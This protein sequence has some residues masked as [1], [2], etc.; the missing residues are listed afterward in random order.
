MFKRPSRY[1]QQTPEQ[2][3]AARRRHSVLLILLVV[4]V[5]A[6][7]L[8]GGFVWSDHADILDGRHRITDVDDVAAVLSEARDAYR[9]RDSG[10]SIDP[11][12]GS[13]QPLTALSNTISWTLWGDCGPCLHAENL[14]LHL[15]LVIG[16]YALGRHLLSQ[17]RRGN[18]I[19][20]WAAAL[21][22]IHPA[23]VSSVAWIGG[24]PYLLAAALGVWSLVIFT[25]LQATSRSH[26]GNIR[27]WQIG[28]VLSG[29]AAMLAHESAYLLPVLALVI[30]A[31]ESRERRRGALSG[32]AP[33]RL[34]ALGLLTVTLCAILLYRVLVLGGLH[35][36][37]DFPTTS[38][39]DN[40]GNALRHFWLL[41]ERTLLPG[42]PVISDAWRIGHGWGAVE[43]TALIGLIAIV[44]I[45]AIGF[46]ARQPAAF[47]VA[48][49][50]V[51]VIP[52][53]GVFPSDHYH[54]SQTL[55][56]ASWGLMYALAY[57]LMTAWR[58]I[59][60][61]LIPGSE[62]VVFVPIILVLSVITTLSNIRWWNH[63]ALFEGEIA[64]DPHYMEGRLELAKSALRRDDPSVA[65]SHALAA[66]EASQDKAFTGYWSARDGYYLLARAQWASGLFTAAQEN[67]GTAIE[68]S[69]NDAELYYWR[70]LT[71]LSLQQLDNAATDLRKALTLRTP[72][73]RASAELG[74]VL[75]EQQRFDEAYPLLKDFVDQGLGDARHHRAMALVLNDAGELD[76]AA[77][78]LE[79]ALAQQEIP[80]ERARLAWLSW[81]LG[82]KQKALDDINM[83]LQMDEASSPYVLWVHQQLDRTTPEPADPE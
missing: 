48:W 9:A 4:V 71:Y 63:E 8:G 35:F 53:V 7:T 57:G 50:V 39:F 65:M 74:V 23:T 76:A 64:N 46:R 47:G 42:E 32:I 75:A 27:R 25:R 3:A 49:F 30:A 54:S 26:S 41:V 12:T 51:C 79:Q 83:A 68:A 60:R 13:W 43:F 36:S 69:P 72:Y 33:P 81:Q 55:Y 56:L 59:G 15:A 45:T 77:D 44:G 78:Q 66:I 17:R 73:P 61:Q 62:G 37:G 18:R 16:L 82:R 6:N 31:F 67:L 29:G 20:A 5:F 38:L 10:R 70:G 52:G 40:L 2:I 14:L 24:R 22:A 19:A 21:Y 34:I 58:P 28:M 80:E 11:A 1:S